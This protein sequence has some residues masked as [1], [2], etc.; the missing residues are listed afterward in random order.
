[1]HV[2]EVLLI[3]QQTKFEVPNFTISK[4]DWGKIKKG[5]FDPESLTTPLLGVVCHP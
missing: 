3:S 4:Q 5:S 2:L 1:M